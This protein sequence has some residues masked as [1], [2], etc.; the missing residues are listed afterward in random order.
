[1]KNIYLCVKEQMSLLSAL[2]PCR[3]VIISQ[4][5]RC[6]SCQIALWWLYFYT[7][8]INFT[9]CFDHRKLMVNFILSC[10]ET[11]SPFYHMWSYINQRGDSLKL[12]LS[13]EERRVV[14]TLLNCGILEGEHHS[15]SSDQW[16]QIRHSALE[17]TWA[18]QQNT[19]FGLYL[20]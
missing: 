1:M 12:R 6:L 14:M 8:A 4:W 16:C 10:C 3:S 17:R 2:Q 13:K 7:L 20:V 9:N 19:G 5:P 15:P 18:M 11:Q